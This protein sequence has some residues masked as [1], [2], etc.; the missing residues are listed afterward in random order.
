M[1]PEPLEVT[2]DVGTATRST[3]EVSLDEVTVEFGEYETLSLLLHA[4]GDTGESHRVTE[5]NDATNDGRTFD[6]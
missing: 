3:E 6:V 4:L 2:G 5:I 1:F